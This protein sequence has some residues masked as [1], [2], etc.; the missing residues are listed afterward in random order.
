MTLH[1][2]PP[3]L[4]HSCPG[5]WQAGPGATAGWVFREY[6]FILSDRA[7]SDCGSR[8]PIGAGV[9]AADRCRSG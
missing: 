8:G 9:N 2:Q 7:E 3:G 5:P 1:I 6:L 4:C